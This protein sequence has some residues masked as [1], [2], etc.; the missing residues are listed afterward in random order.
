MKIRILN[1]GYNILPRRTKDFDAGL[2]IFIQKSMTIKKNTTIKIPTG[3]GLEI[4]H[5]FVG[6]IMPRS[7]LASK[8]LIITPIPI[9]SEYSGEIHV[10]L[11]NVGE[12]YPILIG[13]RIAQIVIM[14]VVLPELVTKYTV[15]GANGFGSSGK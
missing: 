2:D 1:Y 10:V 5:G 15:R 9:D 4:P 8:G 3:F 11:T 12:D 13:E 7:S 14:P 6:Y